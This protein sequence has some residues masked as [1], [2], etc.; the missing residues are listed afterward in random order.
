MDRSAQGVVP[1]TC[2][3][4]HPVKPVRP[5]SPAGNRP[6]GPSMRGPPPFA[7]S[8]RNSPNPYGPGAPRPLSPASGRN[9]PR[10]LTPNGGPRGP[11]PQRMRANSNSVAPPYAQGQRSMSPGPYPGSSVFAASERQRSNS[12]GNTAPPARDGAAPTKIP[13]RKPVPSSSSAG[14]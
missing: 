6:R 4:K 2:L 9:S 1:R 14:S 11:G 12:M 3:S 7:A 10:P 8:G 13:V 5:A